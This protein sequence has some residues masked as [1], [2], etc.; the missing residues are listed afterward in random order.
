MAYNRE[1]QIASQRLSGESLVSLYTID[2]TEIGAGVYRIT[3]YTESDGSPIRFGGLEFTPIP[4]QTEGWELISEGSMPR[5]VMRVSI[6]SPVFNALI[7]GYDNGVG[8]VVMRQRTFARFLDGHEDADSTAQFSVDIYRINEKKDESA[9][10]IEWELASFFDVEGAKIPARQILRDTCT[11][12]YRRWDGYAFDYSK[13]TCPY[14]ASRYYM[15]NGNAT[16]NPSED[17]CG[18]HLSDCKLRFGMSQPLYTR[19]FP[20]VGR[21]Q[22]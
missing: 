10:V 22:I 6:L 14:T 4:L 3:N 12:T 20:G 18:K 9:G 11:H 21:T 7:R 15:K 2:A 5:P 17:S 19:A 1:L 8:A 16:S 13:A